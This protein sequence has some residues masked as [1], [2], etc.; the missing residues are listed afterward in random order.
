MARFVKIKA[1]NYLS[2]Y[3]YETCFVDGIGTE[4]NEPCE[5]GKVWKFM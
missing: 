4:L 2:C 3:F 5:R 1:E